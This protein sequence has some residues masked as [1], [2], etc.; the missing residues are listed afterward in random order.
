MRIVR[1]EPKRLANL[2]KHGLD[3]LDLQDHFEFDLA[4]IRPARPSQGRPRWRAVGMLKGGMVSVIFS[5]LGGEAIAVISLRPAHK[6][7]RA[8]YEQR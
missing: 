3:F 2:A 6:K 4:M 5:L 7:E 1:D 8:D